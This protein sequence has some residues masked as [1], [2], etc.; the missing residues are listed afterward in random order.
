MSDREAIDRLGALYSTGTAASS[1][2][3]LMGAEIEALAAAVDRRVY[4][5]MEAGTLT[6]DV[7]VQAWAEKLAYFKLLQRL[8]RTERVGRSAARRLTPVLNGN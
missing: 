7:A 1:A 3:E 5:A 2:L 4:S 8:G 6:P